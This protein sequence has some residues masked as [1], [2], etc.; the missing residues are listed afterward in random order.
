MRARGLVR[1]ARGQLVAGL[2]LCYNGPH[3]EKR[4]GFL[5]QGV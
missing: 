2:D 3:A 4:Q 5:Q 1:E